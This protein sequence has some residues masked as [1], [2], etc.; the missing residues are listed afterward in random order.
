[1]N[2]YQHHA[3]TTITQ[4]NTA[5]TD[6]RGRSPIRFNLWAAY[7]IFNLITFGSSIQVVCIYYLNFNLYLFLF[8]N[9]SKT[10]LK[11]HKSFIPLIFVFLS[12]ASVI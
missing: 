1:M 5:I 10:E 4:A 9:N 6:T 11:T 3:N 8:K 12:F 7:F 2:Q